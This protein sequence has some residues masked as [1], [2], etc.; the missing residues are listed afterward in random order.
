M[1][2]GGRI[3]D[4]EDIIP[5]E[6]EESCIH[7]WTFPSKNDTYTYEIDSTAP[8]FRS[9]RKGSYIVFFGGSRVNA[10]DYFIDWKN[11]KI[12]FNSVVGN[13][14]EEIS[15]YYIS[16]PD[17]LPREWTLTIDPEKTIYSPLDTQEAFQDPTLGKYIVFF[18]SAKLD[19]A[20]YSIDYISNVIRINP[21]AAELL[22]SNEMTILFIS[23]PVVSKSWLFNSVVGR[24]TYYLTPGAEPFLDESKGRYLVFLGGAKVVDEDYLIKPEEGCISLGISPRENNVPLRIYYFGDEE[25]VDETPVDYDYDVYKWKFDVNRQQTEYFVDEARDPIR[26]AN[27]GYYIGFDNEKYLRSFLFTPLGKPRNAVTF[28]RTALAD[29]KSFDIYFIKKPEAGKYFWSMS[30]AESGVHSFSPLP[31]ESQLQDPAEGC[32]MVFFKDKKLLDSQFN[33]LYAANQIQIS[34]TIDVRQGDSLQVLFLVNPITW[35]FW[36]FDTIAGTRNYSPR[37][38]EK[39]FSELGDGEFLFFINGNRVDKDRYK[40]DPLRNVLTFINAPVISG[41]KCELYFLGKE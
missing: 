33:I 27:I 34:A 9:P 16:N 5:E 11:N 13:S 38:S 32:Y 37:E 39:N 22:W 1:I 40:V 4:S 3:P 8:P 10:R 15:I 19:E 29:G 20:D 17:M 7:K 24:T 25:P 28:S 23:D 36:E 18:N 31:S 2:D 41:E 30:A 21:N 26:K 12:T 6:A 35:G 14:I